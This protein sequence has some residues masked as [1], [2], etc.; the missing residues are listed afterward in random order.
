MSKRHERQGLGKISGTAGPVRT[1]SEATAS[2]GTRLRVGDTVALKKKPLSLRP[3]FTGAGS[4]SFKPV[5]HADRA[6]GK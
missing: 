5:R 2:D 4:T 3:T 6:P 1:L